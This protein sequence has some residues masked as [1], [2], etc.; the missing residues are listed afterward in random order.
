MPDSLKWYLMWFVVAVLSD[1]R[2]Y[3]QEKKKNHFPYFRGDTNYSS[4]LNHYKFLLELRTC[5]CEQRN[6]FPPLP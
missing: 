5:K 6:I 2:D 3:K 1:Q 4:C